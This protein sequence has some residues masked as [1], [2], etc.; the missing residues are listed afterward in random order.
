MEKDAAGFPQG[1]TNPGISRDLASRLPYSRVRPRSTP[2]HPGT[3]SPARPG[4]DDA[5]STARVSD[6]VRSP[7]ILQPT[8]DLRTPTEEEVEDGK[9]Q[10]GEEGIAGHSED[11]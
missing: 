4:Q 5:N 10:H 6:V 3:G 8:T 7:I 2:G 11:D 1:P 9:R